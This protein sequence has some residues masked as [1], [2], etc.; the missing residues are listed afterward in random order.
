MLGFFVG[1]A[2]AGTLSI[3]TLFIPK[4][5][6]LARATILIGLAFALEVAV[7]L[8]ARSLI[9]KEEADPDRQRTTR[10]M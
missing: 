4:E 9:Q 6:R 7:L 1:G 5:S 2:L 3:W 10:G 8:A